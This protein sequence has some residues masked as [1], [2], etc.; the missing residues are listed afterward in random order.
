MSIFVVAVVVVGV[1]LLRRRQQQRA[2]QELQQG[3]VPAVA[4]LKTFPR[5]GTEPDMPSRSKNQQ[6]AVLDAHKV[7]GNNVRVEEPG[8]QRRVPP[9]LPPRKRVE[10]PYA[11]V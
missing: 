6:Q 9:P 8:Q 3:N 10:E 1:L 2:Q 5:T 11:S 7:Q 4:E